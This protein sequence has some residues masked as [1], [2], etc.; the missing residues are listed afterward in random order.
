MDAV[1]I[2][3]DAKVMA[4]RISR[5]NSNGPCL[6]QTICLLLSAG[7]LLGRTADNTLLTTVKIG[8]IPA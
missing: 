7:C 2:R 1:Q 8:L 5:R 4:S 6:N 3:R